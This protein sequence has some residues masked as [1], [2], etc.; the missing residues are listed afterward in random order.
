[1]FLLNQTYSVD[2]CGRT[3]LKEEMRNGKEILTG[4][5]EGKRGPGVA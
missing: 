1:V 3:T 5:L 4:T 2:I